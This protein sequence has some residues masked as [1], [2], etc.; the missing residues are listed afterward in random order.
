MNLLKVF[1]R[2]MYLKIGLM[3]LACFAPFT[4]PH[5]IRQMDTLGI[6]IRYWNRWVLEPTLQ[7]PLYPALIQA[8]DAYGIHATEFPILYIL[9]APL[10][11]LPAP[12]NVFVSNIFFL[13]MNLALTYWSYKT[14]SKHGDY[15]LVHILLIIFGV[16]SVYINRIMPDYPAFILVMIAMGLSF[17]K[18]NKWSIPL[19]VLGLL[20]KPTAIL[21]F[22]YYLIKDIKSV[23]EHIYKWILP[24]TLIAL[25]YYIWGIKELNAVSD[26]PRYFYSNFRNPFTQ[27]AHFFLEVKQIPRLLFKDIFSTYLL[28]FILW[29]VIKNKNY[30]GKLWGILGLQILGGAALDGSHSFIHYYYY[31]STSFIVA[32]LLKSYLES[33]GKKMAIATVIVISLFI[34]DKGIYENKDTFSKNIWWQCGEI[35]S[36]IPNEYKIRN[37]NDYRADLGTCIGKIQNSKTAKYGVYYKN[38]EHQGKIIHTTDDLVLVEFE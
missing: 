4:H 22:G 1:S 7:N 28:I 33:I 12:W 15:K 25:V 17:K 36:H 27:L 19:T 24:A 2:L 29:D 23:W 31:I 37:K 30:N 14:W 8:G 20:I 34:L 6:I 10:T 32:L 18:I 26:I 16:G 11:A 9:F 21:G 5:I 38:V 35:A 13:G 3:V